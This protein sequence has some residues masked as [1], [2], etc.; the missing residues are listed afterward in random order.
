M[1]N[2]FEKIVILSP[3]AVSPDQL[4]WDG[5]RQYAHS[6]S[7][8]EGIPDK[9]PPQLVS[10]SIQN[11]DAVLSNKIPFT[12]E[13]I[14]KAPRLQY[15]G[16]FSTGYDV[17]DIMYLKKKGIALTNVPHYSTASVSQSVFS[18]LLEHTQNVGLHTRSV[19]QGDWSKNDFF[20][21]WESPLIELEGLT[22]GIIGYGAI[23]QQVASI[24]R[25]FGMKVVVQRSQRNSK[26]QDN[27][28]TS[29]VPIEEL[30]SVSDCISLHC[31]LTSDNKQMV[32]KDFL[33]KMKQTAFLINV[34]RGGLVDEVALASALRDKKIAGAGIDVMS[35]EPPPQDHPLYAVP[36]ITIT[37]HNA[38]AT[39]SSRLRLLKLCEANIK[40]FLEGA[41]LN[42]VV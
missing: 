31:P 21:Y 36:N 5:I 40:A 17:F 8:C 26:Y 10:Q 34:A 16:A 9:A 30:L 11:A 2:K 19:K 23:G 15:I 37:P 41:S 33:K 22:M 24:A 42:R 28:E 12:K 38:W 39:R 20:C 4:S 27:N 35:Q 1:K 14:Q 18:H 7:L 32:N 6:F 25:A 3:E 29:F 13:I